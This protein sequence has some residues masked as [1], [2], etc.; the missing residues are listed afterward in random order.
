[1]FVFIIVL[2]DLASREGQD[3]LLKYQT[4]LNLNHYS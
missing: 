4:N 1:M 3:C 2:L